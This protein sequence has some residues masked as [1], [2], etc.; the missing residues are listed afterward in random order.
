M[1]FESELL[2]LIKLTGASA[3]LTELTVATIVAINPISIRLQSNSKLVIPGDLVTVPRRLRHG[4][5]ALSVGDKVM[6]IKLQGG[7]S[8]Y[9]LDAI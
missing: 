8:F 7:Q 3:E 2:Q 5:Y 1:S 4:D 9:V 6:T